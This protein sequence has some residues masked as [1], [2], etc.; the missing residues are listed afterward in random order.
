MRINEFAVMAECV[1]RG[2]TAG[3]T[4]GHE[5]GLQPAAIQ[6]RITQEVLDRICELFVFADAYD[7]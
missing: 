4:I 6:D 7:E 1:E 2:V 3:W 5:D